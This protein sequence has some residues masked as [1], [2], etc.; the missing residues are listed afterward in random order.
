MGSIKKQIDPTSLE[1]E[2]QIWLT[3]TDKD[4]EIIINKQSF[5]WQKNKKSNQTGTIDSYHPAN[6]TNRKKMYINKKNKNSVW[7]PD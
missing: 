4:K 3:E 2:W 7:K 1:V 6:K 5:K